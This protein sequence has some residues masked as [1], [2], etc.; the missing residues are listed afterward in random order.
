MRMRIAYPKK[1]VRSEETPILPMSTRFWLL[2]AG[3]GAILGLLLTA[4]DLPLWAHY[5]APVTML[6]F[7][8]HELRRVAAEEDRLRAGGRAAP[9]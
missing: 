6:P 8:V 7:L 5:V 2:M 3:L 4:F 9:R 1:T